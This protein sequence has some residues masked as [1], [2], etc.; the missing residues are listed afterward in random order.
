MLQTLP[1]SL[2]SGLLNIDATAVHLALFLALL[3]QFEEVTELPMVTEG[4][5]D[6]AEL[7]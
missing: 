7:I 4:H 5:H 1:Q 3:L 2:A 6:L